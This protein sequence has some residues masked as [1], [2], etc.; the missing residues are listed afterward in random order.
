MCS[1]SNTSPHCQKYLRSHQISTAPFRYGGH[2]SGTEEA[3][4]VISP[5]K[6]VLNLTSNFPGK[7]NCQPRSL[8]DLRLGKSPKKENLRVLLFLF[9]LEHY[10]IVYFSGALFFPTGYGFFAHKEQ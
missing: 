4:H 9:F 8:L 5:C 3:V 2:A 6:T 1:S 10:F 7:R